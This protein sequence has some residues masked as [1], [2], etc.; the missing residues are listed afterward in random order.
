MK[1][2][3]GV[4]VGVGYRAIKKRVNVSWVVRDINPQVD[5]FSVILAEI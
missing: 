4:G 5:I 2:K 1:G 3:V